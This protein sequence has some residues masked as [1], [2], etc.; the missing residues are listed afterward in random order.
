MPNIER[1]NAAAD[2]RPVRLERGR[3]LPVGPGD[4]VEPY[5]AV[6]S[7][8]WP[9]VASF[10]RAWARRVTR[11]PWAD[12][13]PIDAMLVEEVVVLLPDSAV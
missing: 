2:A 8:W 11:T 6:E 4:A 10:E 7:T 12:T 3:S 1:I 5:A 9:D 13:V